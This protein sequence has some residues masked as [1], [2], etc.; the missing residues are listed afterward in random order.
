MTETSLAL[1]WSFHQWETFTKFW[2][3]FL[4]TSLLFLQ[5]LK[6]IK[7]YICILNLEII[8]SNLSSKQWTCF[9]FLFYFHI[10]KNISLLFPLFDVID[11][12]NIFW[13][14]SSKDSVCN[15]SF[16]ALSF[17]LGQMIIL[18]NMQLGTFLSLNPFLFI[19][20]YLIE[21]KSWQNLRPAEACWY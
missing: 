18:W 19:G 16:F 13:L 1:S 17:C 8:K 2:Q 9:S 6:T 3:L 20:N 11:S 21:S 5:S 14:S 12:W 7:S 10:Q 15:K 4:E